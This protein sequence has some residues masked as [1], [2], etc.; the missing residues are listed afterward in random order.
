MNTLYDKLTSDQMVKQAWHIP[1]QFL[2]RAAIR[3][4]P[5][6]ATSA[7]RATSRTALRG[8]ARSA[9]RGMARGTM[10]NTTR[11]I[12]PG[13]F[14][15]EMGTSFDPLRYTKQS[16]RDARNGGN[17]LT[18]SARMANGVLKDITSHINP[19]TRDAFDAAESLRSLF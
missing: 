15:S 16:Y 3:A 1:L 6:V 4:V 10:R 18:N 2:G 14:I 5:R 7:I 19:F 17:F 9:A 13:D 8:T 12:N 11:G